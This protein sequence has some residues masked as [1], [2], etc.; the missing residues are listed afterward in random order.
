M[1]VGFD[2]GS[3]RKF[4]DGSLPRVMPPTETIERIRPFMERIGV[5]RV[6]DTTGLDTLGMPV[7]SAVRPGD[8][9]MRGI[10]VYNGKGLTK[11]DS[12]AGAMM[13]AVERYCAESWHREVLTGTYAEVL[14]SWPGAAEAGVVVDPHEMRLQQERPHPDLYALRLEWVEGIELL[15]GRPALVP[16]ANVM[17]PYD[18]PGAGLWTTSSHGLAAGNTLAEAVSHAVAELIERDAFT[19]AAVRSQVVPRFRAVMGRLLDSSAEDVGQI[20]PD[21]TVAPSV[22]LETLPPDVLRLVRAAERDGSRVWLR[23]MTTDIGI[24]AF[25]ASLQRVDQD[26]A[27]LAAGGFG[28]DPS[29][30]IA[31]IRAITEA[32]QGRNV[33]I[34]GVREDASA[35]RRQAPTGRVLWC[36]DSDRWIDFDEVPSHELDDIVED[37]ELMVAALRRVGLTRAYAVDVSHDDIPA[38]VAK[39]I[40]PELEC[41]FLYDFAEDAARLGARAQRHLE[42]G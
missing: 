21:R 39:V 6:A 33:Q 13:E 16:L 7:F 9:R 36:A 24:P 5:T 19:L 18:G 15:S 42:V 20:A 37:I 31:A 35:A 3:S 29:A 28:C 22:R 1:S 32:A 27:E 17:C 30:R 26:D 23:D 4:G 11:A 40:A 38:A 12:H 41:W 25:V 34:Q 14:A 2:L 10:S 8:A